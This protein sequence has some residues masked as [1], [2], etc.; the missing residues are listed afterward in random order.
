[1]ARTAEQVVDRARGRDRGE[2]GD[3]VGASSSTRRRRSAGWGRTC[4]FDARPGGAYRWTSSR[5]TSRAASSSRSTRRGGSSSRGAGSRARTAT[6]PGAAGL[7]DDRDRARARRATERGCASRTATC[8]RRGGRVALA[9]LG[10]LPRAAADRRRRRPG[11][12]P[13]LTGRCRRSAWGSTSRYKGGK[14]AETDEERE[15]RCGWGAWFGE[16]GNAVVDGG[17]PFSARRLSAATGRRLRVTRS[18]P[19]HLDAASKLARAVRSAN[20]GSVEVTRC[21]V[22]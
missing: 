12:D 19:P 9:R 4:T 16:L 3:G 15:P 8:R 11:V 20:G 22:M 17:N 13:W 7:V 6:E 14:M 2:P 10:P 21:S 5:R 1:M 18:C